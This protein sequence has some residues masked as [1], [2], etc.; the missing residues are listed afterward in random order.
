[1]PAPDEN[2]HP[3]RLGG[4]QAHTKPTHFGRFSPRDRMQSCNEIASDRPDIA[5]LD[6]NRRKFPA[7]GRVP[8]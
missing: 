8:E 6:V 1:M 7:R 4:S 5:I 2:G 3:H